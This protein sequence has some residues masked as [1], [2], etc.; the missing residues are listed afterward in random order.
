MRRSN[1][2]LWLVFTV[3]GGKPIFH[4][5]FGNKR[6]AAEVARKI[7]GAQLAHVRVVDRGHAE[8]LVPIIA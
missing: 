7:V 4:G 8:E 5:L 1:E 3:A 2:Y 6:G